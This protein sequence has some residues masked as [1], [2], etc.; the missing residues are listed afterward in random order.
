MHEKET[1][2]LIKVVQR[3]IDFRKKNLTNQLLVSRLQR[4]SKSIIESYTSHIKFLSFYDFLKIDYITLFCFPYLL[5]SK[6]TS[7]NYLVGLIE[8]EFPNSKTHA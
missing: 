5:F 1:I 6:L 3:D 4:F 2:N 7:K 8:R